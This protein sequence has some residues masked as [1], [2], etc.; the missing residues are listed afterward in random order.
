[1]NSYLEE[2]AALLAAFWLPYFWKILMADVAIAVVV[3]SGY[4]WLRHAEHCVSAPTEF[5][6]TDK[7]H[8]RR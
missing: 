8:H 7:R 1:M 6:W 3:L 5:K 4:I 2:A